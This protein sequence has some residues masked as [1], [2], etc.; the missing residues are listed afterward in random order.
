[1]VHRKWN[2]EL[3]EEGVARGL[4]GLCRLVWVLG[5]ETENRGPSDM[6]ARRPCLYGAGAGRLFAQLQRLVRVL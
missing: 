6:T 5:K 1:V 4:G 2:L 3:G